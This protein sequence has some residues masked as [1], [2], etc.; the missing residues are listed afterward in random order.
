MSKIKISLFAL[1][2]FSLSSFAQNTDLSYFFPGKTFDKK[3]KNPSE[4]FHY[5]I[6]EQHTRHEKMIEYLKYLEA[7]TDRVKVLPMGYTN[8]NREQVLVVF[9]AANNLNKLGNI[10]NEHLDFALSK[11]K[12]SLAKNLPVVTW[13][14]YNV[15]GNEPSG[16]E[17]AILTAYYLASSEEAEVKTW[18]SEAVIL[19]EPVINPD[20]R[21]RHTTWVNSHKGTPAVAD[22]NDREHTEAWPMGRTNHYW[23]DLNRDWYLLTQVES[24]N[25]L[26]AYHQWLPNVVTDFHEMG[27][28]ATHF[29]EPTKENAEN[30]L[31]PKKVYKE[32]NGMFAKYFEKAMNDIGSLYYSKDSFDNF[33]PGYGS[34]YPDMQGG[35]GL[36]FEQASSRGHV[37]ES[38]NGNLTFG[39]TVRNQLVNCLATIKASIDNRELLLKHQ[40]TFFEDILKE[41][42]TAKVKAYVVTADQDETK[43]RAFGDLLLQHKIEF[44]R[45]AEDVKIGSNTYKKG[46]SYSIP[47][48]QQQNLL[49]KSIFDR[50]KAF[51]D[52]LFYDASTWNLALAYGLQHDELL[53]PAKTGTRISQE[54]IKIEAKKIE[55]SDYAY[56]MPYTDYNAPKALNLLLKNDANVKVAFKKIELEGKSYGYGTI[57][58]HVKAQKFDSDAL[59]RKLQDIHEKTGV[60]FVP[61]KTGLSTNGVDLGNNALQKV[62]TPKAIMLVGQGVTPAEAGEIWHLLDTRIGMPITKVEVQYFNRISLSQYTTLVLV[63]G[64][65]DKAFA[66]KIKAFVQNGG[67]V[68]ALKTGS[69]WLIKN[70][71]CKEK[72]IESKPDTS[73]KAARV[74]YEIYPNIEG[75][76][77][78]GGAIFETELDLS[79]P[80]GFGFTTSKLAIYRNNNTIFERSPIPDS[81]PL[82]YTSKPWLCG[83]VHPET[84]KKI[85][86]SSAINIVKE[87]AG[88]CILFSDNPN[89]RATWYGTN[90]LFLNALFFGNL[91]NRSSNFGEEE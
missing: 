13:L 36:L 21:D 78:T 57:L 50:P 44:Y 26:K 27:T 14:G 24:Q 67:T 64:Q 89:F 82:L 79:H 23:F 55:K 22:P 74:P 51:A 90:K 11:T 62:K 52:S 72:L 83:Y 42:A 37:Q 85:A 70:D 9:S 40:Q 6:G 61:V 76:K 65:Y 33:Y 25:R 60:E 47:M 66:P 39:F 91:I 56:L 59:Q 19:M 84:L 17:A 73:R 16:G 2:L 31:V 12:V 30:P 41:A 68:I 28:N 81:S 35:L 3:V 87:G 75:A 46:S 20:G 77:I 88:T 49:I 1:I 38:Q 63:S 48:T 45:P 5:A 10:R 32:L 15:H 69:E 34:S 7:T 43:M 54:N 86:N 4:I 80:I 29:F 53:T 58:I 18:L 8:E 71:V